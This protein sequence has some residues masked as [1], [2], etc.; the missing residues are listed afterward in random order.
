MKVADRLRRDADAIW[1]KIIEHPFVVELYSG[2][3]PLQKFKFYILHDYHYLVMAVKNFSIIASKADSI[4][5]MR[6]VIDILNMEAKGEFEGYKAFLGRIG[7]KM[8]DA[9]EIE[10]IPVSVSYGS[11][12]ISTSSL[13]SYAEAI[14]AVLPCFWS[15][16]EIA[17]RHIERLRT[18]ENQLYKDWAE[19]YATDSYLNLVDKIKTLVNGAGEEFPYEKLKAMFVTASRFEYLFWDAVYAEQEWPV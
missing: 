11:F 19:I 13:K 18:H 15:Y 16:A 17:E 3:L 10:P 8:E 14:T 1:G 5:A 4:E 2:I 9:A 7:Y 12:L 6:E